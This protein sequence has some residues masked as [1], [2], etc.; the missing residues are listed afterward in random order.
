MDEEWVPNPGDR[1]RLQTAWPSH[2]LCAGAVGTV[3]VVTRAGP[4]P[5]GI[6]DVPRGERA[7]ISVCF[8]DAPGEHLRLAVHQVAPA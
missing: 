5:D 4:P 2:G 8:D 7:G 1:V 6:P 3:E